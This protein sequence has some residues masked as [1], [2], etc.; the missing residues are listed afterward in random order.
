MS[1]VYLERLVDTIQYYYKE[2]RGETRIVTEIL[3]IRSNSKQ[4]LCSID[5]SYPPHWAQEHSTIWYSDYG[6]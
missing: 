5:S 1:F 6:L 2:N 3:D 4:Y